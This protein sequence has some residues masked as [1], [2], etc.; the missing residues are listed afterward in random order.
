MERLY[1]DFNIRCYNDNLF[2]N[3][4]ARENSYRRRGNINYERRL[5]R[6]ESCYL[7]GHF[8]RCHYHHHEIPQR[9]SWRK[10]GNWRPRK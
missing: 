1:S 8:N 3:K 6:D 2:N 5:F 10:S 4:S 7:F 9:C